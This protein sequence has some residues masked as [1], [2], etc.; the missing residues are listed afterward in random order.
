MYITIDERD[1]RPLYQQLVDEIKTLIARGELAQGTSLPPVR[2]VASD[3]GVNLN[4]VAFAYRRLQKEGLIR[5]RHGSGAVV[6]SQ[7]LGTNQED[8]L[9]SQLRTA[10]TQLVLAGLKQP[11]IKALINEELDELLKESRRSELR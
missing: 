9:R 6:I 7:T 3:L 8:R 5:V 2:Q 10:L 11:E 4:T 1:G